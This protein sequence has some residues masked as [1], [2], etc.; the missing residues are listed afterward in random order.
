MTETA[1]NTDHVT[2]STTGPGRAEPPVLEVRGAVK[3]FGAVTALGGVDLTLH[4]RQVVGL[5]GDN[6]AGKSTLIKAITGVHTLDEGQILLDGEPVSIRTP[7][8]ARHHGIEAVYQD[9]ALFDNLGIVSNLYLG[10]ELTKPRRFRALG[11]LDRKAMERDARER[12]EKLQVNVPGFNSQIGLMSG[13]QR[14]AVAVARAVAF[15]S[16]VLILDEPTAAL[17][18][19]E[20]RNVLDTV[21][22]LPEE[23][24]LS[25]ILISHNMD[26]VVQVCDEAVVMRQGRVV[27]SATPSPDTLQDIVSMIVGATGSTSTP[28]TGQ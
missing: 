20:T 22:R 11:W 28:P 17:G 24:D 1:A 2:A 5:L 10:N 27:G 21:S 9:L 6:G 13:G 7:T 26:H 15:A 16:R 14:Q 18:V 3:R 19:R 23:L 8:E 12:L 25:V 4:R